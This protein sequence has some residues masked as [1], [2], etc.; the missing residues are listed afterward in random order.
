MRQRITRVYSTRVVQRR[1]NWQE[2]EQA[3]KPKR[4]KITKSSDLEENAD[5]MIR[6]GIVPAAR[7]SQLVCTQ[8]S[9]LGQGSPFF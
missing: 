9:V 4:D 2:G 3:L 1:S 5:E 6:Y 8:Q 7:G